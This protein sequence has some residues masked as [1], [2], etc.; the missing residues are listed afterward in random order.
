MIFI[1]VDERFLNLIRKT[2]I[3]FKIVMNLMLK[4]FLLNS[5]LRHELIEFHSEKVITS[6]LTIFDNTLLNND[7]SYEYNKLFAE[8]TVN[9]HICV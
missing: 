9:I 6:N 3:K 1:I 4:I 5:D 7:D 8:Q 2:Q